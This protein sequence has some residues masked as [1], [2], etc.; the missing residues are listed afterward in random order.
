MSQ[1]DDRIAG[2]V[3][4]L[5]CPANGRILH[6]AFA[7]GFDPRL[8]PLLVTQV[9]QHDSVAVV[10]QKLHRIDIRLNQPIQ[11]GAEFDVRN[12]RQRA[13]QVP[14]VVFEDAVIATYRIPLLLL[15]MGAIT[16]CKSLE[17][18]R[19]GRIP[20]SQYQSFANRK[21]NSVITSFY[22]W[23]RDLHLYVGLFISPF[24]LI[25][26]ISLFLLNHAWSP[27]PQPVVVAGEVGA[28]VTIPKGFANTEGREQI[29][30]AKPILSELGIAGEIERIA[31]LPD[32]KRWKIAVMTPGRQTAIYVDAE[33]GQAT[34]ERTT[35]GLWDAMIYL[36][37]SPGPH[38]VALRGNWVF[39]KIWKF[40]ADSV[41]LLLLFISIS[42]IYLWAVIKSE[43]RVG[44][45]LLGA[46]LASFVG[47]VCSFAS[48]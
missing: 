15:P 3:N 16:Y 26:S 12:A 47:V 6:V 7:H 46:G 8:V 19:P 23:T 11:I 30:I 28:K 29:E 36:H 24:I 33:T 34:V 18:Y 17:I 48:L 25:F 21:W 39:T 41:T 5:Q 44:L 9:Q 27:A 22:R 20:S 37:K 43:R 14:H 4:L 13:F 10:E 2:E 1:L 32:K 38:N 31:R 45:V 40:L 35:T 42:G